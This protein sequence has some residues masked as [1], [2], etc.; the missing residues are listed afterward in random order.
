MNVSLRTSYVKSS[1]RTFLVLH[2]TAN[3]FVTRHEQLTNVLGRAS[4]EI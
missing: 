1:L 4:F 2:E 3:E